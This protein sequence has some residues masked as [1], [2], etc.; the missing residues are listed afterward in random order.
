MHRT[1]VNDAILSASRSRALHQWR[2]HRVL[3]LSEKVVV[4]FRT[5]LHRKNGTVGAKDSER[6]WE[7]LDSERLDSSSVA[8]SG[9]VGLGQL[10][11]HPAEHEPILVHGYGTVQCELG[12]RESTADR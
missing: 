1:Q 3:D 7:R 2:S 11:L 4:G 6:D 5:D 12:R 9:A 10:A 8:L